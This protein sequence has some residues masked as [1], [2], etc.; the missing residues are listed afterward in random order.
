MYVTLVTNVI[1]MDAV[2]ERSIPI[3]RIGDPKSRKYPLEIHPAFS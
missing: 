3:P 1:L 2:N